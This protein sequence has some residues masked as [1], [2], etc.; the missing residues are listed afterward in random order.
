MATKQQSRES[1]Y[2]A[3]LA[4]MGLRLEDCTVLSFR[5]ENPSG[6]GPEIFHF[7]LMEKKPDYILFDCSENTAFVIAP[8]DSRNA[9]KIVAIAEGIGG[10]QITPILR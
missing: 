3:I 7:D 6:K 10:K 2:R 4:G 8:K 5:F 9:G 1:E